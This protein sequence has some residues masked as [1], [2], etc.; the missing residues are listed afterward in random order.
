[1]AD[2]VSNLSVMRAS[3]QVCLHW[4]LPSWPGCDPHR[5]F[6]SVWPA[7]L[8]VLS[9]TLLPLPSPSQKVTPPFTLLPEPESA[10]L[11]GPH[12]LPA[13]LLRE[14]SSPAS[15]LHPQ[16]CLPCPGCHQRASP[17]ASVLTGLLV[18]AFPCQPGLHA[19]ARALSQ[20]PTFRWLPLHQDQEQPLRVWRCQPHQLLP[21]LISPSLSSQESPEGTAP[22]QHRR[23]LWGIFR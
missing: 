6:L 22:W 15:C 7:C 2:T 3:G 23:H 8:Y 9:S 16:R 17:P 10:L 13:L 20:V 5:A 11:S 18:A 19:A 21:S 12:I 1:M 4:K 14:L